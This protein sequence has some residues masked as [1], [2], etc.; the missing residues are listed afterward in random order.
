MKILADETIPFLKGIPEQFAE[1]RYVPSTQFT[2]EAVRDADVLIVRSVDQCTAEVLTGSRVKLI[3]TATIGFDHIDTH[4][5]DSHGIAWQNAPGCNARSVAQY[6]LASLC[7]LSINYSKE[8][9][10]M[11]IG[12]VGVGHVGS[13]VEQVCRAMGMRV[14]YNDPPR[15]EAEG[16]NGFVSLEEI[17]AQS[18]VVTIHTP[19]TREGRFPT[20]HLMNDAFF[21]SLRRGPWYINAARGGVND[22]DALLEAISRG[23]VSRAVID[24]WEHEPDIRR[25]MLDRATVATPHIAGFSADG[26]ANATRTCLQEI[27]KFYAIDIPGLDSIVLP[28]P[29]EPIIDLDRFSNH[30]ISRA[31]LHTFDP[32]PVDRTLRNAPASFEQLRAHYNHPREFPAYEV[33]NTSSEEAVI[34]QKLG[35]GLQYM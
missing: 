6:V 35:F 18:D 16:E 8:L 5:C 26:K 13:E 29:Q 14:L 15:A 10:E 12:I 22:T 34:L 7:L 28:I 33:R 11:T 2:A 30:R 9:H 21:R 3:T 20:Y 31:I 4:Y 32:R 24:C 17:A 25:D 23:Q 1:V 27:S 19:L